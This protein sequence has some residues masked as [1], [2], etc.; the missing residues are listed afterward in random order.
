[1]RHWLLTFLLL[2]A[3]ALAAQTAP[4]PD[5]PLHL[6][7]I[8]IPIEEPQGPAEVEA[9]RQQAKELYDEILAG[10]NFGEVAKAHSAGRTA[11][12]GG[13]VSIFADTLDQRLQVVL[14]G[15]RPGQVS[16]PVQT[17]QGFLIL[18]RLEPAVDCG[19]GLEW[20]NGGPIPA[21]LDAYMPGLRARIYHNWNMLM[22]EAAMAPTRQSG[23]TVVTFSI[24]RKGEIRNVQ[25]TESSGH[26]A[27]DRAAYGAVT[28]SNPLAPLP[29]NFPEPFTMRARFCY[30]TEKPTTAK[31]KKH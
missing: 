10:A 31:N 25:L 3:A 17:K 14:S 1:M 9:A 15:L 26:V 5:Q 7:E 13:E 18:K 30:N 24:A 12:S 28:S 4:E 11:R 22:P 27:L 19:S 6:G 16:E 29:D 2:C 8:V 23:V 20:V 21:G